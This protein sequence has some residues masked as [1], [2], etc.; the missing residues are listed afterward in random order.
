LGVAGRLHLAAGNAVVCRTGDD[1]FV[2]L[3]ADPSDG[4]AMCRLADRLQDALATPFHVDGNPLV[5]SA[6]V[7]VAETGTDRGS[8]TELL[9]AGSPS[10]GVAEPGTDR[11]S[12]TELLRAVDV[13]RGWARA[14]GGGRRMV[15]DPERDAAEATRFSLLSGLVGG[16]DRGEFRLVYQPLV[17]LAD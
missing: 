11:G 13:A 5:V 4:A 3:V 14:L 12:A 15:Y 17:R 1:E 10:G 16:I 2:V 7:G 8:A 9:R 6:S